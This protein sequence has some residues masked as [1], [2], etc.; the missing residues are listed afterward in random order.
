MWSI[1][2]STL[3]EGEQFINAN[4][5]LPQKKEIAL[6]LDNFGVDYIELSNPASSEQSRI[7][8]TAIA[9]LGLGCKTLTHTRCNLEDVRLAIDT[10]VDGV[11]LLFGT[12]KYLRDYAHG[13]SIDYI[14]AKAKEVI[15]MA[16]NAGCEVRFSCEDSFR[17]DAEDLVRVYRAVDRVGVDRIGIADTVGIAHPQQ[18]SELVSSLRTVVDCDIEVHFHNDTG[19]AVANAHSAVQAGATHVDTCVLGIGERNGITPLGGFISRMYADDPEA[20]KMKYNLPMI[21]HM[22]HYVANA[23]DVQVPFNNYLSGYSAFS[24]KAGMHLKAM[25]QNS[26]TYEA[27]NPDDFG[28][29]RVVN[30]AHRLTGWN[31][32]K[33]RA[34]QLGLSLPDQTIREATKSIKA[35]ADVRHITLDEVDL[36]LRDFDTRQMNKRT[37][38]GRLHGSKSDLPTATEC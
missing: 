8:C 26:S 35:A 1:I 36:I 14:I 32:V 24:H 37:D 17:S 16:K 27:L 25:L 3:R 31:A 6:M 11:D 23:V 10:G 20:V 2:D 21:P 7:D 4:F 19:C 5:S 15:S 12:S 29:S 30:V 33:S 38:E 28:V 9:N 13:K 22:D 18:V 34:E